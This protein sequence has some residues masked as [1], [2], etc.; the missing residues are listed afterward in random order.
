MLGG[1]HGAKWGV[2]KIGAKTSELFPL[3]LN[4]K[5]FTLTKRYGANQNNVT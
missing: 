1:Q 2:E 5:L 3:C 4:E